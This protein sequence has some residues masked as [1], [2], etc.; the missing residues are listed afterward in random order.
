MLFRSGQEGVSHEFHIRNQGLRGRPACGNRAWIRHRR[1]GGTVRTWRRLRL[2]G[3]RQSQR[4]QPKRR[5][6]ADARYGAGRVHHG[7]HVRQGRKLLC[8]RVQRQRRFQVR[9]QRQPGRCQLGQRYCERRVDRLRRSGQRLPRQCGRHADPEGRFHGHTHHQHRDA[10]EHRLDRPRSRSDDL[11]LQQ[12]RQHHSRDQHRNQCRHGVHQRP[13]RCAVCQALSGRWRRD[14]RIGQRKRLPLGSEWCAAADLRHR[15]RFRLCPQPRSEW[16][17]VL[18]RYAGR[19]K[20][21]KSEPRHRRD[22]GKLE[23]RPDRSLWPHR[24]W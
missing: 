3:Q 6:E 13:L 17:L 7:R 1:I 21:Q 10:A 14:R 22:R 2:D 5:V 15:H 11:A 8:H 23:Y 24:V 18:D 12:R 4:L 19:R 20:R 16:N 9:Q